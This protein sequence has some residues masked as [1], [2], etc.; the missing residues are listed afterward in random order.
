MMFEISLN[1]IWQFRRTGEDA[2]REATVPG[3]L[4]SDLLKLGDIEDPFYRDNEGLILP[5][6][7]HSYEYGTT[8]RLEDKH[9]AADRLILKLHG[10][11]TL[12]DISFNG[13]HLASTDNMF[14]S[15][16]LDVK[17]TAV[18]GDNRLAIVFHSPVRYMAERQREKPL[19]GIPMVLEGYTHLRKAHYMS[20]WDWGP[21]LPDL[22]I[23]RGVELVGYS[24]ARLAD[25]SVRQ[26]HDLEADKA[27]LIF[28]L[29]AD[30]YGDSDLEARVELTEPNGRVLTFSSSVAQN[31]REISVTV[32]RPEL[33]WPNGY[34]A[35]PLYE[36][37]VTLLGGGGALD[38]RSLRIGLRTLT[39]N[40]DP[41]E[42]GR[43]FAFEINGVK[44]FSMGADYIPEDN[45]ISRT[46]SARTEALIRDCVEANFNTIRVWGGGYYPE[47]YFFE[48][49]DRYGIIVWQDLM[50]SC[51]TYDL[52]PEFVAG[53]LAEIADNVRSLRHHACLGLICGNNEI[54]MFFEDGRID[55]TEE[56]R[57][58]YAGFF[59]RDVPELVRE[60]APQTFYWPGSPS[61]GGDF[62][63]TNGENYGDGHYW[64]VWHGN[65]PFAAYRDTYYRYMSEFGF[66]SMPH[67]RTIQSF[68]LPEERNLFSYV[69]ECHQ[70]NPSGNQ[71]IL[72][73]LAETFRYP[74]DF[75]SLVYVSQLLQAEAM[76]YGVE[77]WR[78][79]RGR[80]MGALYW[81]LNDCW[82]T[83]SWASLDY[84]GRWKALHYAA[85]RFYQPLLASACEDG[86]NVS[87][88]ASNETLQPADGVL[89]WELREAD[90]T[91]VTEGAETFEAAALSSLEV[92]SRDFAAWLNDGTLQRSRFVS[93]RWLQGDEIVSG[94]TVLFVPA[95]HFGLL[96]ARIGIE[97]R[98]T[99]DDYVLTLE[100]DAFAAY[101]ELEVADADARFSD[102][103]FDLVPGDR[104]EVRLRKS[105]LRETLAPE[106]LKARLSVRSLVDTYE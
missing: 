21:K 29:E 32:E 25:V 87:F 106:L 38:E 58:A 91:I 49:C 51:G 104:K 74:K 35:Q 34:G 27:E 94:G 105:S 56:N 26:L 42:W 81:Q 89:R 76:R 12:A 11:D 66:E 65:K 52:N 28:A 30:R 55:N 77:H 84:E 23:W 46:S 80:C 41:D 60:L 70:K 16:E 4:L 3:S 10:L 85:K 98:E 20:G 39:V 6:F 86:T 100:A 14:R 17:E 50:F 101:V 40:T 64:D 103:C 1:G 5:L 69:M 36:A 93:F 57:T 43:Q 82:P 92:A 96:P 59:E 73:Y 67:L 97:V 18:D 8:F 48:L 68:T 72:A 102:N 24:E 90:G 45:F 9:L 37:K 31:A 95:K 61:S 62:F 75:S 53:A 99:A 19:Y 2:W 44:L 47:D 7:D 15:Y 83:L 22:G 79:H 88:H 78:R 63:E 33:W 71:K 54:E 13:K